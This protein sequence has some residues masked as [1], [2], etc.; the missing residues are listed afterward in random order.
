MTNFLYMRS[1]T[2]TA[3]YLFMSEEFQ[4]TLNNPKGAFQFDII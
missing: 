4:N 3:K 1:T 2:G